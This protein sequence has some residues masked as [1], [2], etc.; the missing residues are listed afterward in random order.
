MGARRCRSREGRLE[1]S[2]EAHAG[3]KESGKGMC[4][5]LIL[6]THMQTRMQMM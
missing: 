3:V 4:P 2:R 5:H 6:H 1:G